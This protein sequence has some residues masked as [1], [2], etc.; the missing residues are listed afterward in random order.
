MR[1][2]PIPFSFLSPVTDITTKP[3]THIGDI[4]VNAVC[5]RFEDGTLHVDPDD[6][7]VTIDIDS[8]IWNNWNVTRLLLAV[9]EDYFNELEEAASQVAADRYVIHQPET[10]EHE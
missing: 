3:S 9:A 7:K 2:K 1:K 6:N 8:M 10:A 5:Y 4:E